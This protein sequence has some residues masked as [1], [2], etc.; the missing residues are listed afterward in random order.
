MRSGWPHG[1]TAAATTLIC[2]CWQR[3]PRLKQGG[4]LGSASHAFDTDAHLPAPLSRHKQWVSACKASLK[5]TGQD[6]LALAQLHW[7]TAKYAPLQVRVCVLVLGQ[8][9]LFAVQG[10]CPG[11]SAPRAVLACSGVPPA[12][13]SRLS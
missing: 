4:C 11:T 13:A 6:K 7:S 9:A 5:R 2:H 10:W 1:A 12:L 8:L 3:M